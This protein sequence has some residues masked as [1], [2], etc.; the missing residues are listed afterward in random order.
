MSGLSAR[1]FADAAAAL[2]CDVAAVRAVVE[3]E[4]GGGWFADVR[5]SILELDGPGGFLDGPNLPKILFEAHHFS[6]LTGGRFD[7]AHPRISA[8]GWDR[9]LYIG[10]EREY[11]RLHQALQLD[12][13]AAL[14]SASWGMF[15][16]MGFNHALCGYPKVERF[17]DAMKRSAAEHLAAFVVFVIRCGLADELRRADWAGFARGYNGPGYRQN[18]YDEKLAAA[19]AR[20]AGGKPERRPVS[21][22]LRM[23]DAGAAVRALQG[24][25]NRVI[26]PS[27]A[28][29]GDF[30]PA[31]R[32][33]VQWFQTIAGLVVDGIAGP[34]TLAALDRAARHDAE[35]A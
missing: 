4:S 18:R 26:R 6:R 12:A 15:Q 22:A 13:E 25:L 19:Y 28:Q 16:I 10:G 8:P 31:T 7:A 11:E 29:D 2:G 14:K 3:V 24:L 35:A 9:S 23:G 33:A 5:A 20:H 27:I 1:D 32:G 30:G 21:A 34:A 17:V